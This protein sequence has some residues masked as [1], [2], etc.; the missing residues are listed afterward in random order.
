MQ[1]Y[2]QTIIF[3]LKTPIMKEKI[4]LGYSC[5]TIKDLDLYYSKS[6]KLLYPEP[7]KWLNETSYFGVIRKC[8]KMN[9]TKQMHPC[10]TIQIPSFGRVNMAGQSKVRLMD[11]IHV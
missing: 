9:L 10:P 2:N 8:E 3:F 1:K 6:M 7:S 5:Q 11:I 4:L